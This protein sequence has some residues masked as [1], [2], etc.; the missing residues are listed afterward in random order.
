MDIIK[1]LFQK[2]V[3]CFEEYGG[4]DTRVT[5]QG[6]LNYDAGKV[7][8]LLVLSLVIWLPFI[9]YDLKT[10]PFPILA[11]SA[12]ILLSVLSA[13]AIAM[14]FTIRFRHK[15]NMLLMPI[16]AYIS[17]STA[18]ITATSGRDAATYV[19]G[20]IYVI[21]LPIAL[22]F[23]LEFKF[24]V[25]LLSFFTYFLSVV[26]ASPDYFTLSAQYYDLD[27]L[28]AFLLCLILSY[29]LN[30]FWHRAWKQQQK[31]KE[32]I[33]HNEKNLATI[34]NL[35]NKA[36]AS[37]RA[38]TYFL[39][40]MS[41]EIRT[42]MNA[43]AG[44]AE[45]AM[46]ENLPPAACEHV[47]TIKQ[48]SANLL[49]IIND[50]LDISKIE[51][52]KLEIVPGDYLFSSLINDVINIIRI[53]LIDSH[54][55]FVVNID[56][57]IPNALF[58]DEIRIRQIFL[59]LLSNAVKYTENGYV[60]LSVIGKITGES[61]VSLTIEIAD[62]GKGI[63]QE[64]IEKLFDDFVQIDLEHNKGIEGTGLGLA[65]TKSI[66]KAIGGDI[67]VSSKYGK[68][69]TFTVN[70]PQAVSGQE[71]LASV[72]NSSE[73]RVL[74]YEIR[75]IYSRSIVR[76]LNNLGVECM[77]AKND[78]EFIEKMAGKTYHF[79]F[80]ASNL[81][82]N[83]KELCS[84][85][86]SG[87]TI[88][89]LTEFGEAITNQN[90][91]KL[92]MP[93]HSI[94][95]ANVLNGL[96]DSFSYRESNESVLRFTAPGAN[97]LVVDDVSTNLSVAEGLML[98]YKMNIKL[99]KSGLEAIEAISLERYDL[100]FMDHMMPEMNGIEA[101]A[102]IRTLGAED[103][104]FKN[105][106]IIALTANAVSGAKEMLLENGFDDFLSKPIETVKLDAILEK[107]IP[108]EKQSKS[109]DGIV[110][111]SEAEE[112]NSSQ[113]M[114]I[115]GLDVE[116]GIALSGGTVEKY[117]KTLAIFLRDG[118]EKAGEINECL[119]TDNLP[120]YATYAH[121]L[122]SAAANI[123]A[124]KLSEMAKMLEIAGKQE[125]LAFIQS[126][127]AKLLSALELLM[128]NINEALKAR[129]QDERKPMDMEL[130]KAELTKLAEA[131]DAVNPRAIKAAVKSIQPYTQALDIGG[132]VENIL[133]NTSIGKYDEA[134]SMIND[135]LQEYEGSCECNDQM[136]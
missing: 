22:P 61:T 136:Q 128:N 94:S 12:R 92:A 27:I 114:E 90:L 55:L 129:K 116:K 1:K 104:Y 109:A 7:F 20:F 71:K 52:G 16:I 26:L 11:T 122:K 133:K 96:S 5:F 69:S 4:E 40:K 49:S 51:M 35:A 105:V 118:S 31:L 78:Q 97:V 46:R 62:S 111:D 131:M 88:V 135:L 113:N 87:I 2:Y 47:L 53:R 36:E 103:P 110:A 73:K 28:A 6:E 102:R 106:P 89:L 101:T 83:V 66:V 41:H 98:P 124:D 65:I 74:V 95:V 8:Y 132:T 67:S 38:K 60:S 15:P 108:K 84:S 44:M 107:W 48:A 64:H 59:N 54:V 70:L 29:T 10:H 23:P 81:Y 125:D 123:G 63:K 24:L 32:V 37:A 58:G 45:L 56:S 117:M 127:N 25:S 82:E 77:L 21:M 121:A 34:F 39:A 33:A 14:K 18:L 119:K 100:V 80:I 134:I 120:L 126:H 72:E 9:P 75:E 115:E 76:T 93:V 43:I 86:E 19:G 30:S 91:R 42:P 17:I 130:L 79:V 68:G 50:I 57:N 99:C 3:E 13:C 112:R 85:F